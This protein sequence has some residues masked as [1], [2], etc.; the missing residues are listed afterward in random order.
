MYRRYRVSSYKN[1]PRA[2]YT[3]VLA[4]LAGWAQEL[5]GQGRTDGSPGG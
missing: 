5:E 3:E 4:W 1:L 2:R